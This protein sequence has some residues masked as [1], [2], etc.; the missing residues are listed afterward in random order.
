LSGSG[1]A[2]LAITRGSPDIA[3]M[4]LREAFASR[5]VECSTLCLGPDNAGAVW[6]AE[7]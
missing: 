2:V 1:S 4:L 6:S 5:G 7:E 3:P